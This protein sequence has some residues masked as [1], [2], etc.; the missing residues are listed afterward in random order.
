MVQGTHK[1]KGGVIVYALNSIILE[2]INFIIEDH[3]L[4]ANLDDE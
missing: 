2:Q 3:I 1:Q 4:N